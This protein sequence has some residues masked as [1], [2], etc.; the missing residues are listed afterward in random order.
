MEFKPGIILLG[1][2][3]RLSIARILKLLAKKTDEKQFNVSSVFLK[4]TILGSK[5]GY[6][7]VAC[8]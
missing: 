3:A 7:L 4:I 5:A 8:V 1:F 6:N 2:F